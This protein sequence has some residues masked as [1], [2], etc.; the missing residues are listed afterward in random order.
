MTLNKAFLNRIS[1]ILIPI[2]LIAFLAIG[3]RLT[4]D[5]I[6]NAAESSSA[7]SASSSE[8][9]SSEAAAPDKTDES[10]NAA[11][12]STAPQVS[13]P[14]SS[15]QVPSAPPTVSSQP[16]LPSPVPAAPEGYFASSL[17]IGDSRTEGLR[18][19]GHMSGALFFSNKGMSVNNVQKEVLTVEGIGNVDLT[20]VLSAR[21]FEKI[22]IMLGINEIGGKLESNAQK[23]SELIEAIRGLQPNAQIIIQANLHVSAA[24]STVPNTVFNNTRINEYNSMLSA[25]A[26]GSSTRYIDPNTIFDDNSGNLRN[27]CTS[28][29][30]HIYAKHYSEWSYWLTQN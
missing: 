9:S 4:E 13:V 21:Q 24:K 18:L 29:G 11:Q 7:I 17:F 25:L 22:Y 16:Q 15:Q 12:S 23:F 30:V 6:P 5:K 14:P 19:Y 20:G 2:L 26:N 3:Y 28:D 8:T 1:V 10:S 27:E